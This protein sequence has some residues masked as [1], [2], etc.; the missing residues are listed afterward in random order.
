MRE[1][2]APASRPEQLLV[3]SARDAEGLD[4]AAHNLKD[5]LAQDASADLADVAYTLQV[6]RR[7]FNHRRSLVCRD[8]DDA[9]ALLTS[10]DPKRVHDFT[11]DAEPSRVAFMFPGQGAQYVNMGR[12]LY[13]SEPLFREEIDACARV[14]QPQLGVDLRAVLY[15]QRIGAA[16][17]RRRS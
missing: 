6:G 10:A 15:P 5:H 4:R 2:A 12:R 17:A 7:R 16:T 14:L 11:G 3:L 9:I 13:E 1:P 8:R